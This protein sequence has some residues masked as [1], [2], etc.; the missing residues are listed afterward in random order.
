MFVIYDVNTKRLAGH[1]SSTE[2]GA[3]IS[4][5]ALM[6]RD[7]RMA[8]KFGDRW[9]KA[10]LAVIPQEEYDANIRTTKIVQSLMT[11]KDVVIDINTPL[12]CDPSSETYWTM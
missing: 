5:A 12:C 8:E 2:R 3:K 9:Q 4:R 7:A 10:D 6:K 1:P 11:G